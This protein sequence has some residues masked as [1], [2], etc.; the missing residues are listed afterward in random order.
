M[1]F[2]PSATLRNLGKKIPLEERWKGVGPFVRVN[3][4]V[5]HY[6]VGTKT[7]GPDPK[8]FEGHNLG[9]DFKNDF[10]WNAYMATGPVPG[11]P[12]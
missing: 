10:G 5:D 6:P 3:Y 4:H 2:R 8:A 12:A 9:W 1:A 11:F 7:L